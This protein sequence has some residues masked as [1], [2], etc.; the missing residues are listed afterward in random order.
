V[1]FA[2]QPSL[3]SK[4]SAWAGLGRFRFSGPITV[5]IFFKNFFS[6]TVISLVN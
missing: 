2:A 4:I 6:E 5:K 3:C 1:R